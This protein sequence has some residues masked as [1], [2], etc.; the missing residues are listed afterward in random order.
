M[1]AMPAPMAMAFGRR[2]AAEQ[3]ERAEREAG[4]RLAAGAGGCRQGL[5][6][7]IEAIAVHGVSPHG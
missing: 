7:R 4:Q 1:P 6:E 5:R 2:L 3:A